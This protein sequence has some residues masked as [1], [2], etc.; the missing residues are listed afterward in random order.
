MACTEADHLAKRSP[1]SGWTIDL[2]NGKMTM[3]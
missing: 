1:R 3:G 2:G